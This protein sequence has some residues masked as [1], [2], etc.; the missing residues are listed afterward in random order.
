MPGEDVLTL[1][2]SNQVTQV[3]GTSFAAP[4]LAALI[5]LILIQDAINNNGKRTLSSQDVQNLLKTSALLNGDLNQLGW[6]KY[7]GY[8]YDDYKKTLDL[9]MND[10][11][12]P[13]PPLPSPPH[14]TI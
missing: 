12:T 9:L 1:T 11:T 8:G 5:A 13:S 6:D 3:S 14:L 7:T 10:Q 4:I 2:V